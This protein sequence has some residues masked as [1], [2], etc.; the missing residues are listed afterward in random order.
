M[1]GLRSNLYRPPLRERTVEPLVHWGTVLAPVVQWGIGEAMSIR[2]TLAELA[3][4][5]IQRHDGQT[6]TQIAHATHTDPASMSSILARMAKIG[7]VIRKDVRTKCGRHYLYYKRK[8][9]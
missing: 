3:V 9:S 8:E 4:D 6:A 1:C 5:Q 7:A 2:W